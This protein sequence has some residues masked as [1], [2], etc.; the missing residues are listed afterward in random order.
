ML[1]RSSRRAIF[2][3]TR[4]SLPSQF[5]SDLP[6]GSLRQGAT[7]AARARTASGPSLADLAGRAR[8]AWS[9]GRPRGAWSH[10]QDR[11]PAAP[12]RAPGERY[13]EREDGGGGGQG[14]AVFH[15]KFGRGVVT[16]IDS[17]DD[18]IATVRFS[19]WGVKRIKSRF[20]RFGD[21]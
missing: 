3:T 15:E 21:D 14:Q 20:L 12:V 2:G 8:A 16:S 13:V 10:P 19:G 1:F 17:G 5:L 9:E 4:Y 7:S 11:A 6:A 18:P